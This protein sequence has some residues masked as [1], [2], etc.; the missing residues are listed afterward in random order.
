MSDTA[1]DGGRRFMVVEI[2]VY[3]TRHVKPSTPK[4]SS[5][6]VFERAT[7]GEDLNGILRGGMYALINCADRIKVQGFRPDA[8]PEQPPVD[9]VPD[10]LP[11]EFPDS[12]LDSDH[13]S[14]LDED[15]D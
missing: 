8:K 4:V 3:P 9:A 14:D 5:F 6:V 15:D 13:D 7:M 11:E 12:D 10:S 1:V 2:N